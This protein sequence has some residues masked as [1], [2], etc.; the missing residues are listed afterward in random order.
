MDGYHYS[1]DNDDDEDGSDL[2]CA[3]LTR[4]AEVVLVYQVMSKAQ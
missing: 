3:A 1:N 2:I 4:V